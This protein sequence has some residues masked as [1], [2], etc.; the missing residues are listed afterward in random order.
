MTDKQLTAN[1]KLSEFIKED[2][3]PYQ[4]A[5]IQ[6][7]ADNLQIVRDLLQEYAVA[8]KTVGISISSG[9]RTAS[10]YNRLV[11]KG[12]N[13]SKTS[14]HFCGLQLLS[15]PTIG[16][17]DLHITNCKLSYRE[18]AAKM[19]EWNENT[20]NDLLLGQIIYERNPSSGA[21]WIHASN[22][23]Y[24]VFET[25]I[26]KAINTMRKRYLMSLD[27]GKTYITFKEK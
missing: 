4:L 10:D 16:A 17:A 27:N 26:A 22:D 5:L 25:D 7:L 14:D 19:I 3:N 15:K 13:P 18:I 9:V 6:K 2:P 1:F 21:E 20:K 24:N 23:W 11:N 8:G 12:Y